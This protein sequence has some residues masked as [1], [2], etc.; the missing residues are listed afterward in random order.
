MTTDDSKKYW[1]LREDAANNLPNADIYLR[2]IALTV[3]GSLCLGMTHNVTWGYYTAR[4]IQRGGLR[5]A[6]NLQWDLSGKSADGF[7]DLDMNTVSRGMNR[8]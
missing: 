4:Y 8:I 5:K 7:S 2:N 3:D 1:Q 6:V